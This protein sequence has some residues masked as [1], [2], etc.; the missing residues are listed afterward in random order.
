MTGA[1]AFAA[2]AKARRLLKSH[3]SHRGP[4]AYAA[5][6]ALFDKILSIRIGF[7]NRTDQIVCM[8][9]STAWLGCLLESVVP[10]DCRAPRLMMGPDWEVLERLLVASGLAPKLTRGDVDDP[11]LGSLTTRGFREVTLCS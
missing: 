2:V 8:T 5:Q 7:A 4:K 6:E 10:Q 3:H 1:E 9:G 11:L